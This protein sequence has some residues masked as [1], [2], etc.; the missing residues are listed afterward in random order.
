MRLHREKT[1]SNDSFPSMLSLAQQKSVGFS[2][3]T[4][5]A[6]AEP[7]KLEMCAEITKGEGIIIYR[8]R[9]KRE[10]GTTG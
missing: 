10:E 7:A 3:G 4:T 5:G 1:T 8:C 6:C 9:G 2:H